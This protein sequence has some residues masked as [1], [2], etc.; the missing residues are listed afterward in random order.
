MPIP[1]SFILVLAAVSCTMGALI[2]GFLFPVNS[3]ALAFIWIITAIA[4]PVLAVFGSGKGTLALIPVVL[5]AIVWKLPIIV[6]GAK[7]VIS[8][9]STE[10]NKWLYVPVFFPN[11]GVY[12]DEIT[13]FF[14]AAGVILAFF[15][16][17]SI[18]VWRNSFLTVLFTAPIIFLTFVIIYQQPDPWFLIGLLAVYLTLLISN[19]LNKQSGDGR[20]KS[21]FTAIALS[22]L[23]LV[24][25]Y[26]L[27][28][29]DTNR[30]SNTIDTLNGMIR[31]LS[32]ER[33]IGKIKSG[34]GWPAANPDGIWRFNTEYVS[35]ADAG[36]R[37]ITDRQMLSITVNEAGTYYLRGYSMQ[38]FD[39]RSWS[40]NSDTL[41]LIDEELARNMPTLIL[42]DYNLKNP[43]EP[44]PIT[45][46]VITGIVDSTAE[47]VY[48]PYFWL[49]DIVSAQF[50]RTPN[51]YKFDFYYMNDSIMKAARMISAAKLTNTGLSDYNLL[52]SGSK[53]YTQ[54]NSYTARGL[55]RL[56]LEAG[57]DPAADRAAIA[58]KVAGYIS[59]VG[60]YT[61]APYVIP[62]G[63]DFALYFLETAK[64]GYCVHFATAAALMLRALDVPA[65]FTS[66][67]I[68][69]VPA[70]NAGRA[71]AVT[72]RN[73][74]AWVEV[75]YDD[76]GWLPLEVT[77]PAT[78][79][80]IPSWRYGAGEGVPY[81]A[82]DYWNDDY[83]GDYYNDDDDFSDMPPDWLLEQL[84]RDRQSGATDNR[85]GADG[86]TH[87]LPAALRI[88]ITAALFIIAAILTIVL[89]QVVAR[90]YRDR[91]Y[92]QTDTNA[93][94]IC[95]WR[96][97]SKLNS[98]KQ[99]PKDIE[100]I[101][102]KARFSQ[103]RIS[104]DERGNMINYAAKLIEELNRSMNPF[105]RLWFKWGVGI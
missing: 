102:L 42:S 70:D 68:V 65:R 11:A 1:G 36:V 69:T 16:Y 46:M 8:Y 27:T 19:A 64:Q 9:I 105:E 101:A 40:A 86:Q 49:T 41:L 7:G 56:A 38:Y 100:A 103:H 13:A 53:A 3:G 4:L 66:G 76:V 95:V 37:N 94:V 18:C 2:T 104:E 81:A 24:A 85:A 52:V 83:Y 48:T 89:R 43:D 96:H 73:A 21:I 79:N 22:V 33:G 51:N 47:I 28:S 57:I 78:N 93:A 26:F 72:D 97:I 80:G 61:L 44:L 59:S 20:K 67:Y 55:R 98:R 45:N 62:Q 71:C 6:E 87:L 50:G 31:N 90:R 91:N 92:K 99:P 35:V 58:E 82:S 12:A 29:P 39:G 74:H 32:E 63:E 77:P 30:R 84:M 15:L 23:L 17:L 75:Y 14:A 25:A 88:G 60:R 5:A 54:I 10:Y 34:I